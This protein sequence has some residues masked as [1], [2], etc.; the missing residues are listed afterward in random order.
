MYWFFSPSYSK[1]L[2][3]LRHFIYLFTHSFFLLL[4]VLNFLVPTIFKAVILGFS[5]ETGTRPETCPKVFTNLSP[6]QI[7][8]SLNRI[9]YCCFGHLLSQHIVIIFIAIN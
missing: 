8:P 9:F 7:F 1:L 5:I 3:I 4:L 2:F 6:P